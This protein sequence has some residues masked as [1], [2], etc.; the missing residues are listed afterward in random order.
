MRHID[1]PKHHA[2]PRCAERRKSPRLDAHRRRR[3]HIDLTGAKI[4]RGGRVSSHRG[5]I[6]TLQNG[7]WNMGGQKNKPGVS[8]REAQ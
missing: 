7:L 3:A 4:L 5:M 2:I 8:S 1:R 6:A